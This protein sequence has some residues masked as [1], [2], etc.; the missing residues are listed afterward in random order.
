MLISIPS[1]FELFAHATVPEKGVLGGSCKGVK[2][3]I[4]VPVFHVFP[5]FTDAVNFTAQY[6]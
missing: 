4:L 5:D 2:H 3:K 1:L 6:I